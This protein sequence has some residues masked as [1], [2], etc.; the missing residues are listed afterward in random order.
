M[1]GK[2]KNRRDLVRNLL[3]RLNCDTSPDVLVSGQRVADSIGI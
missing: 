3:R 1:L 2:D